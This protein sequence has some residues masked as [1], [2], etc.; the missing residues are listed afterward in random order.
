MSLKKAA[1]VRADRGFKLWDLLIY[2]VIAAAV[3]ALFLTVFLSSD[4]GGLNGIRVYIVNT[5]VLDYDFERD[6]Y[7]VYDDERI[8]VEENSSDTLVFVVYAGNGYNRVKV[9]K[10]GSVS[11]IEAD[12]RS[13]DCV[14]TPS[15]K[16]SGSFIYCSPHG[17]KIM[18]YDFGDI[19]I[20]M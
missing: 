10:S 2:G 7:T 1:Q 12:C 14:Y 15:I 17:V 11:V 20:I 16:D 6:E 5:A 19:D 8:A 4:G 3:A 13:R 18:P 9:D